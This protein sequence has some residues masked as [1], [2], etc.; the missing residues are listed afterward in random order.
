MTLRPPRSDAP[1][2]N[3][4][5]LIVSNHAKMKYTVNTVIQ[6]TYKGLKLDKKETEKYD[7]TYYIYNVTP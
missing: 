5:S 3:A 1:M 6:F 7:S 4:W 2:A